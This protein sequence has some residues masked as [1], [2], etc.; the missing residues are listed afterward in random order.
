MGQ[1]CVWLPF[2]K[3][4]HIAI[5]TNVCNVCMYACKPLI[6]NDCR[7]R[8][9]FEC[10]VLHNDIQYDGH[11]HTMPTIYISVC[12]QLFYF[13]TGVWHWV[14]ICSCFGWMDSK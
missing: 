10:N 13:L 1:I 11:Y 2:C 5:Y 6:M 3:S 9:L 8:L 14:C 4:G 12:S 7:L